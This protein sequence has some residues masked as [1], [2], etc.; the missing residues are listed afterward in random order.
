MHVGPS[1]GPWFPCVD[2]WKHKRALR[3]ASERLHSARSLVDER[4][5]SPRQPYALFQVRQTERPRA[6][7]RRGAARKARLPAVREI[8]EISRTLVFHG[9]FHHQATLVGTPGEES[10]EAPLH[11]GQAAIRPVQLC[12]SEAQA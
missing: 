12:V 2:L 6:H 1:L 7:E 11:T 8:Y 4:S 5:A 9:E 3:L 10:L